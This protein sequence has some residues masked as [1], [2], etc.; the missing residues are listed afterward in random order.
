MCLYSRMHDT[1]ES[2]DSRS[3]RGHRCNCGDC[4]IGGCCCTDTG[5]HDNCLCGRCGDRGDLDWGFA[6]GAGHD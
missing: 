5:S 1:K 6:E 2:G 4:L 3:S